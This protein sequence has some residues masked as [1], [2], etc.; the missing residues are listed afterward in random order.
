MWGEMELG[1]ERHGLNEGRAIA[2]VMEPLPQADGELV[3]QQQ[4]Q[5]QKDRFQ[6]QRGMHSGQRAEQG[7]MAVGDCCQRLCR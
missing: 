5:P 7:A 6:S 2:Q 4:Q 1:M 3:Q